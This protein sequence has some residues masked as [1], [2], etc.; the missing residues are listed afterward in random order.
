[1]V[2]RVGTAGT[3]NLGSGNITFDVGDYAIYN[4]A[5]WEKS[6]TTDAV[7][8]VNGAT[9]VVTV[10]AINELTGDVTTSAASGSQSKVAT[11]ATDAV[12]TTKIADGNVT[13]AKLASASVDENKLTTSVAGA[14][15]TG[16]G[17]TALAVNVDNSTVEINSDTV[18]IKDAGVT[19]AKLAASVAGDGLTGGAGSPL[20]VGAGTGISV[21]ANAVSVD[22][23][24]MVKKSMTAGEALSANTSYLVR[25]AVN[26]ETASRQYKATN[27]AAVADG[28]F[29]VVGI[30]LKTSAVNAG[31]SVDVVCMGTH[32]LGSS[33]TAFNAADI[34][35]PVY[36][37]T[38]GAWTL[39][40]PTGSGE[41][42]YRLGIVE[43]TDKIWV[44]DKQL[45]GVA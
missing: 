22:Y 29:Y 33:D 44:G 2:Y 14:G 42:V 27:A 21:A 40:A 37:G 9:G 43:A 11:I 13:L 1:M 26:G 4:G 15:L 38:A 3:Q 19:E 16:G 31:D 18:R 45:N 23:A 35:K 41:A 34:G 10:N 12:T 36:L 17:G 6:D 39:T 32:T 8:S 25:W 30:A 7:A 5:T 20:A 28:K 24:P